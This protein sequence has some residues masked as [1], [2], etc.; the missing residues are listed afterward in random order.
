MAVSA[1]ALA[2]WLLV[3]GRAQLG[4]RDSYKVWSID[5]TGAALNDIAVQYFSGQWAL[6][7]GLVALGCVSLIYRSDSSIGF[8]LD[9]ITPLLLL[10]LLLP[11]GLTIAVNEFLPFLE[12]RRL[13]MWTPVIAALAACGLGNIRQPV[14]ALVIAA[15]VVYGLTQVDWYRGQPDW[16]RIA[17]VTARY[18]APGDL[19]LTDVSSGDYALRYYL[20][21]EQTSVPLLAEGAR[22]E[23]LQYQREYEPEAYEAW[24]PALLDGQTTVWLMYWFERCERFQLAGCAWLQAVGRFRASA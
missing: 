22:Y 7:I 5:L 21:R 9:R 17:Q 15:L 2:P 13:I 4:N 18:A 1:L 11:F 8:R 23:A 10:W 12:P 16:R 14:R 3:I 20:L 24:L 19:I 6:M